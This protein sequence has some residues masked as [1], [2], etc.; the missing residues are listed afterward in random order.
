VA[1]QLRE[2]VSAYVAVGANLG[3]A[4]ASVNKALNDLSKLPQT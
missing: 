2:P 4:V 1:T 3:D